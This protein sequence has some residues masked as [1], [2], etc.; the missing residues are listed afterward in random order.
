MIASL[1]IIAFSMLLFL[2]W[3]RYTCLLILSTKTTKDYAL[4]VAAAN[5]LSFISA[6]ERLREEADAEGRLENLRQSLDRDYQLL[7]GLL[8]HAAAFQVAGYSVEQRMLMIDYYAMKCWYSVARSFSDLRARQALE[9]MANIV[10]H[11]ANL[12]GERAAE[13]SRS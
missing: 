1:L 12:M 13:A 10:A 6:Q 9:E 8:N 11:F 4:E 5:Q 2:Y 7:T 3:F